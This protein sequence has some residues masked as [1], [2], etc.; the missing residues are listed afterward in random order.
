MFEMTMTIDCSLW[1][2]QLLSP[3]K[4]T[5]VVAKKE[6]TILNHLMNVRRKLDGSVC[7]ENEE[8]DYLLIGKKE[9]NPELLK[10]FY[11]LLWLSFFKKNYELEDEIRSMGNIVFESSNEIFFDNIHLDIITKYIRVGRYAVL[12]DCA[13]LREILKDDSSYKSYK[14]ELLKNQP[15]I[16]DSSQCKSEMN[17]SYTT[18]PVIDNSPVEKEH[19]ESDRETQVSEV[20]LEKVK[21]DEIEIGNIKDH[22]IESTNLDDNKVDTDKVDTD[23]VEDTKIINN[24][25]DIKTNE[26]DIESNK[27]EIKLVEDYN[28]EHIDYSKMVIV[29]KDMKPVDIKRQ[30]RIFK[31]GDESLKIVETED[32]IV[33]FLRKRTVSGKTELSI[34]NKDYIQRYINELDV[35]ELQSQYKRELD[36]NNLAISDKSVR[37]IVREIYN[38]LI[39][40]A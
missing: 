37:A 36:K 35:L 24:E 12:R 3:S 2:E 39:Y 1:R 30:V 14:E 4:A 10:E 33:A 34:F 40:T 11:S 23:K 31:F 20:Q 7:L 28:N 13:N 32:N 22:K 21:V 27:K 19:V 16:S 17:N 29:K 5:I 15:K 26:V 38:N 9:L 25:V 8:P 6:D 18:E